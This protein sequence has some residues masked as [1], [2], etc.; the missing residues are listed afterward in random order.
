MSDAEFE[1]L[2]DIALGLTD[3]A[4]AQRHYLS[5]RGVQ[6][7]LKSVYAKL[8][9]DQEAYIHEPITETLN[10][11]ARAVSLA[12]RRGLINQAE[13]TQEEQKLQKWLKKIF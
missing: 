4:I 2:I 9:V 6:N 7:R 10:L 13:L 11:R 1:V 3:N 8:G 12:L 5:R